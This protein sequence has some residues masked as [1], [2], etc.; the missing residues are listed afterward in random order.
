MIMD[1][2]SDIY[3]DLAQAIYIEM[4]RT[5]CDAY[6]YGYFK[7]NLDID[8]IIVL[9]DIFALPYKAVVLRLVEFGIFDERKAKELLRISKT[10][11]AD[12]IEL[13]D[14]ARKWQR[15]SNELIHYGSLLENIAFNSEH[16][17]L[18]D[19]R[20]RSDKEYLDKLGKEF[21]KER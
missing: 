21:K 13:T 8:G 20:E 15:N 12:R 5:A 9:M 4:L 11:V 7:E 3:G 10:Y 2:L 16:E 1:E 14:K 18:I 19:T 6:K 17:L